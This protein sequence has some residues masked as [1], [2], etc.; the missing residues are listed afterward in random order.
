LWLTVTNFA[1]LTNGVPDILTN[2][3]SSVLVPKA[4]EHYTYDAD[5]NLLSDG[6]WNYAWDAENRLVSMTNVTTLIASAR[7]KLDFTYDWQGRRVQKRVSHLN[8]GSWVQDSDQRFVYDGWNLVAVLNAQSAV[9]QSFLWGLDLSGSMQGAGGVGGLLVVS[10]STQGAHFTAFD[11]NGN[12]S[13]L[14][15]AADGSSLTA[16]Y[17]YGPFGELLRATGPL[18]K[19][20]P[21][22]WSTHYYDDESDLVMYPARPYNPSTGRF[23]CKD[24][25]GEDGGPNLYGFALNNG[26]NAVD[27]FGW[28]TF[29]F[30]FRGLGSKSVYGNQVMD[31]LGA[32]VG[33]QMYSQN[34]SD[35][36]VTKLLK[37]MDG[38]GDRMISCAESQQHTVKVFGYS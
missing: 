18:A 2:S 35:S 1:L 6:L 26:V 28:N 8:G 22:R 37:E 24:P 27:P 14:V 3:A 10:N 30:G 29:R 31:A 9:V 34:E 38:N 21:F 36:A 17:E 16:Q 7:L 13:A 5:G 4:S 11:G 12:V 33:A 15:S 20:N 32:E 23:L 19:A 25:I